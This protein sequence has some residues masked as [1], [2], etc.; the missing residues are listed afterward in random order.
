MRMKTFSP[1]SGPGIGAQR[2]LAVIRSLIIM[3]SF[4]PVGLHHHRTELPE[5]NLGRREGMK[6]KFTHPCEPSLP[7]V[8]T[9]ATVK[10]SP[11]ALQASTPQRADGR[12]PACCIKCLLAPR[13][14]SFWG[15]KAFIFKNSI[16]ISDCAIKPD[17]S[18]FAFLEWNMFIQHKWEG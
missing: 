14:D 18:S 7:M 6:S 13:A 17:L 5:Q 16:L 10:F 4:H 3:V 11:A 9:C 8:H 12:R 2:M 15:H 1:A